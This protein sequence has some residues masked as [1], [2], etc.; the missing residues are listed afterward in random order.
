[1]LPNRSPSTNF[2]G[3]RHKYLCRLHGRFRDQKT[4]SFAEAE[5]AARAWSQSIAHKP[6]G[7][8]DDLVK[9]QILEV[10]TTQL[11]QRIGQISKLMRQV[12]ELRK[13]GERLSDN[14]KAGAIEHDGWRDG[15]RAPDR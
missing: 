4:V 5:S 15:A 2:R 11:S 10:D 1:M 9:H 8:V 3:S 7:N 13:E 6:I 12:N 14:L